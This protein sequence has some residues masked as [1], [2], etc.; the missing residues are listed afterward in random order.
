MAST[1]REVNAISFCK[2][3]GSGND[4][5]VIDN[6]S[7]RVPEQRL[8]A[9][10]RGVCRR[11]L[12]VGA[13]GLILVEAADGADF[14]WRFFNSDA[15]PAEMCG[16]GARCVARFA[17]LNGIAGERM[18]FLT[19]VGPVAA[20]VTGSRVKV[21]MPE[22][23]GLR[24]S[25]PI[26]L[27]G[28]ALTVS[29]VNTGVPHVVVV[30]ADIDAQDVVSLGREIRYH[31]QFAPA[32]SNVNLVSPRPDGAIA[33]R[34][35]ERGVED[36]TLACGTGAIAAALVTA[37]LDGRRSPIGVVTRGG[38]ALTIFFERQERRFHSVFLEG[39]AR[40]IYRGEICPE[41]WS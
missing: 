5:I 17:Y 29:S 40:L 36:E 41:A 2:M 15:S 11:K 6:R 3:S 37:A 10:V 1:G 22:P 4:F 21:K 39:D 9:F 32:G 13:D 25:Y 18:T 8:T 19:A 16:N 23:T 12:S 30:C 33:V 31:H 28:G 14:R 27:A 34:T 7:G 24:L 26:T 35:Y 38:E 20:E